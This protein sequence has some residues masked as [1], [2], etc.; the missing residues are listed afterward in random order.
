[1]HT[2]KIPKWHSFQCKKHVCIIVAI[3][4][5]VPVQT[6]PCCFSMLH[7][8]VENIGWLV[9]DASSKCGNR[10]DTHSCTLKQST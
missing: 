4:S 1:M 6:I 2:M 10:L 3:V 9:Y 5:L 7:A 8:N